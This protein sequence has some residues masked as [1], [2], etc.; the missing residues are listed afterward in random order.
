MSTM[1]ELTTRLS[2]TDPNLAFLASKA[3]IE[4]GRVA[5]GR[6][7]SVEAVNALGNLLRNSA[8]VSTGTE[9]RVGFID[10]T[11]IS[12]LHSAIKAEGASVATLPELVRE[13]Q[14]IARQLESTTR[15]SN[16]SS[17]LT[18]LQLFCI[19]LADSA[20]AHERSQIESD[21]EK[22]QWS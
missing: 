2:A 9:E 21:F 17:D 3:A 4:L 10:P 12:V 16:E 15:A 7:T 22:A 20:I 18:R 6:S 19:G 14:R 13:A 8:N 5:Q 11:T 1:L